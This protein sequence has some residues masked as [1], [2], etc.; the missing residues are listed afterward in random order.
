VGL[1]GVEPPTSSLSGFCPQACFRRIAPATCANDLPLENVGDRCEP[2][3]SDGVWTKRGPGTLRSRG[4]GRS[5][6]WTSLARRPLLPGPRRSLDSSWF[7]RL[8]HR[9]TQQRTAV[10]RQARE[11]YGSHYRIGH[12]VHNERTPGPCPSCCP[13]TR[14]PAGNRGRGISHSL[15]GGFVFISF[16]MELLEPSV[17]VRQWLQPDLATSVID[18]VRIG[19]RPKLPTAA[20]RQELSAIQLLA[21]LCQQDPVGQ[22]GVVSGVRLAGLN[23][24]AEQLQADPLEGRVVVGVL[25]QQPGRLGAV[26]ADQSTAG[27]AARLH[28]MACIRAVLA[29]ST[30]R[31]C[32]AAVN[33]CSDMP[34]LGRRWQSSRWRASWSA[35]AMA[36]NSS[37]RPGSM[38]LMLRPHPYQ[39]SWAGG[40][41][42]ADENGSAAR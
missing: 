28:T 21:T 15:C 10:I 37:R 41:P 5:A 23:S 2:L 8:L 25:D 13:D 34:W 29:A 19:Q 33:S 17:I 20:G 12:L 42:R 16:E 24:T 9:A 14:A 27:P 31:I 36:S 39:W 35:A 1:G 18:S 22:I 4:Q 32:S 3:G 30:A 11:P 7:V 6:S 38:T 40:P 26:V